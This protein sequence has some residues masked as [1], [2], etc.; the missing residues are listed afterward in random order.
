MSNPTSLS[1][2]NSI[3]TPT[4][5]LSVSEEGDLLIENCQAKTLLEKYGSPL[6]VVSEKTLRSNYQKI[7]QAVSSQWPA[8]V[9]VMYAIKANNTPAIR[10]IFNEEGAGGDCF[11]LGELHATFLGGAD[12][13]KIAMNGNYKS[14][15]ELLEAVKRGVVVNIDSMEEVED[16]HQITKQLDTTVRVNLR[17]KVVSDALNALGSD[18]FGITEGLGD[19]I[20]KEKWGFTFDAARELTRKIVSTEGLVFLGYTTHS[21]RFTRSPEEFSE[22]M[23]AFAQM[24]VQLAKETGVQVKV[25]DLGGGWPRQR[26]PE[27]RDYSINTQPIEAYVSA[28][29]S[30]LLPLF[31]EAGLAVPELWLEPGRYLIGN[32]VVLLGTVGAIKRDMG[33]VW[34][35]VDFSTNN[36]MRI[37]TSRSA[38]HVVACEHM[39]QPFIEK[40]DIVGPTCTWS[41]IASDWQTP[42]LKRGSRLAVL[43]VGMY[44]ETASTQ[45]NGV[46]RPATVLVNGDDNEIIKARETVDDVFAKCLMPERLKQQ[47]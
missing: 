28:I 32:G 20:A 37:D 2:L 14:Y 30:K 36:V 12:A 24:V 25:I 45:F 43:D 9:N 6:Y 40:A 8:P 7:H 42:E 39:Q 47:H 46:P 31:T 1:H 29:T 18:Y 26:D 16:L 44:A 34:V 21:G 22:Y 15:S 19:F 11:G 35:T 3:L 13:E 38:H 27:S 10:A 41:V 17:L 23:K 5:H 4:D 33:R